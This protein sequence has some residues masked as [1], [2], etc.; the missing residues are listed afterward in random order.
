MNCLDHW[1]KIFII[2]IKW[3]IQISRRIT[4][5][6]NKIK[7]IIEMK[8]ERASQISDKTAKHMFMILRSDKIPQ[9]VSSYKKGKEISSKGLKISSF[10]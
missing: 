6:L 5:C 1:T 7:I 10:N 9:H 4:E 3:V 8:Y 2:N